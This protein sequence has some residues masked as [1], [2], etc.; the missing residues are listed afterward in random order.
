MPDSAPEK[1]SLPVVGNVKDINSLL[2]YYAA[3]LSIIS[4]SN[5]GVTWALPMEKRYDFSLIG[6]AALGILIALVTILGLVYYH[7]L[8]GCLVEVRATEKRV[9]S[10]EA[11]VRGLTDEMQTHLTRERTQEHAAH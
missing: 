7:R 9:R 10:M 11:T 2:K 6:L 4:F 5:V 3:A 8:M 1:L